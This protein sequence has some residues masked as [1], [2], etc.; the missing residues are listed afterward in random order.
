MRYLPN[1]PADREAMLRSTGRRS[2][3]ELFEQIPEE[4]K[5][6][7]PLNLPGPLS[8]Q[9]ILEYFQKAARE[10]SREY[11]SLLGAGAYSHYRPVTID[12]LLSRGEFFTAYTPY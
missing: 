7:K 2:I 11:A 12:S 1:S 5:L 9:E 6:E 10:S 8:E 4:L 3:R